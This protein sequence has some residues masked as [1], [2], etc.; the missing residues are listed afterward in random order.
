M[1]FKQQEIPLYEFHYK[2]TVFFRVLGIFYRKTQGSE[3]SI[4]GKVQEYIL[5]VRATR[6]GQSNSL[7]IVI[8]THWGQSLDKTGI[9]LQSRIT[10]PR[11]VFGI[12]ASMPQQGVR[13]SPSLYLDV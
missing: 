10:R 1:R 6:R 7:P 8:G 3:Q 11:A 4:S 2:S 13:A 9:L 5:G 12:S